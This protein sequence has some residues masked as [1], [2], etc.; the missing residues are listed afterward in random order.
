MVSTPSDALSEQVEA[1]IYF[2]KLLLPG[3]CRILL[4]LLWLRSITLA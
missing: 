2:V 4:E 1:Q 3:R